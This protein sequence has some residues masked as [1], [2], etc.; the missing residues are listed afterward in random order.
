MVIYLL[1]SQLLFTAG[2]TLVDS[3]DSILMLY[4]Y[5]DFVEHS[6]AVFEENTPVSTSSVDIQPSTQGVISTATPEGAERTVIDSTT[7][8]Q[9]PDFA[10][11]PQAV[12]TKHRTVSS[13]SIV[14]TL[15]SIMVAFSQAKVPFT[16]WLII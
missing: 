3:L 4:S 1:I 5:S 16:S 14:L 13:L 9:G 8:P 6:L 7:G 10:S 15:M 2:M 12:N 11:S